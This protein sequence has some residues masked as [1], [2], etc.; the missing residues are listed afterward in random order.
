M[1]LLLL[2]GA[3]SADV[4]VTQGNNFGVDINPAN[5]RIAMDLLGKIWVMPARGGAAQVLTEGLTPARRPRWSPDGATILYQTNSPH[6]S[7]LWLLDVES[8]AATAIGEGRFSD[9]HADWHPSGERIVF[10]SDRRDS[11]FDIWETDLATGLSWRLSSHPGDETE[12]VWSQD[13]RHLAYIRH[14]DGAYSLVLR[15]HGVPDVELLVT[16]HPLSAPSWR[17]DGTLIAVRIQEG[18]EASIDM[19]ILSEPPLVRRLVADEAVFAAPVSWLNRSRLYYTAGGLIRTRNFADRDSQALDF[20]AAIVDPEP[21]PATVIAKRELDIAEPP[22]ERLVIRGARLYDGIWE[23]YRNQMDVLIEGGRIAAVSARRSWDDATV[24][25]LGNVTVMPGYI[26]AWSALPRGPAAGPRTLAYGVTTLVTDEPVPADLPWDG[27]LEPGPRVLAVGEIDRSPEGD[28]DPGIFFVKVPALASADEQAQ[29]AVSRWREL[30]VPAV[31]E[32]IVSARALGADML[33]G[34]DSLSDAPIP[35]SHP[36]RRAAT[37]TLISGLADSGTP[38]MSS[39]L[40]SRQALEF[41]QTRQ[42]PRRYSSVPALNA[43]RA[44]IILGSKPNGLPPGLA[45]HG[46]L[47]ALAAA[48]LDGVEVLKAT[49]NNAASMLGLENQIGRITPGAVADLVLVNGDPLSNPADA[50]SLVAVVRNGRF[51]SLIGLIERV[52]ASVE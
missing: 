10:S 44:A 52:R 45:L 14:F 31:A 46:E 24:L 48:G 39:L 26:D 49:G 25:D 7:R 29:A 8:L 1:W 41:G 19:V 17:P 15:R 13:G 50:L 3:A 27:D 5:G 30:G 36:D 43:S 37:L 2:C 23:R 38:G 34:L 9:Q 6:G 12:P 32:S 40:A 28:S 42:P 21:Q 22:D 47:R 20:R 33:I 16:E 11:G 51:Y 18:D 4:I 35:G